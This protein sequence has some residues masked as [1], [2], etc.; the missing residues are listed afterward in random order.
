MGGKP[1]SFFFIMALIG[2]TT[3][4]VGYFFVSIEKRQP[5]LERLYQGNISEAEN[6]E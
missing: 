2:A 4:A 1:F 3:V 5:A 6:V